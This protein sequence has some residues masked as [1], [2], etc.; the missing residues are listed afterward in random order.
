MLHRDAGGC[1]RTMLN[2]NI[3]LAWALRQ[4]T[5]S[6]LW[7]SADNQRRDRLYTRPSYSSIEWRRAVDASSKHQIKALTQYQPNVGVY[8]KL[9]AGSGTGD[10]IHTAR[11]TSFATERTLALLPGDAKDVD[12]L[13]VRVHLQKLR[14]LEH[15]L[16]E[17]L[18]V[19]RL[20]VLMPRGPAVEVGHVHHRL[21]PKISE[22]EGD[23]HVLGDG[24]FRRSCEASLGK[25][26]THT[27]THVLAHVSHSS[28]GHEK[29]SN[30]ASELAFFPSHP[31]SSS[32]WRGNNT[33]RSSRR[34]RTCTQEE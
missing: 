16:C 33:R 6:V 26:H 28:T 27:H 5:L 4:L 12:F 15:L 8:E 30:S 24:L 19:K 32:S 23:L 22:V 3:K 2:H 29:D 7:V 9:K 25:R 20:V 10:N 34:G 21:K 1:S 17:L 13:L 11:A 18:V 14:P 31:P